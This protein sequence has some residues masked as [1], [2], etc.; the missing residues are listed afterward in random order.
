MLRR[1]N[2]CFVAVLKAL[3]N[4][5]HAAVTDAI[6]ECARLLPGELPRSGVAKVLVGSLSERVDQYT[7]LPVYNRLAG[8]SCIDVTIQVDALLA[9]G[10]LAQDR[11]GHIIPAS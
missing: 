2:G 1:E 7:G 3:G 4:F 8:H 11:D 5:P 9:A 6:L 10:R